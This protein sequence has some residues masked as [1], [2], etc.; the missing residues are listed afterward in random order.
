MTASY[1]KKIAA[2]ALAVCT[3]CGGVLAQSAPAGSPVAKHGQLKVTNGKIVDQNGESFPM[4]GMSFFWSTPS[5]EGAK[6]YNEGTVKWLA[7]DWKVDIVRVAMNPS[8]RGDWETVVSAAIKYGIYVIIDWH[9]HN[10]SGQQGDA[11]TFFSTVSSKYKGTPNVL[12]EVYNEPC[13]KGEQSG[14]CLGEDWSGIRSYA[15]AVV[16]TIRTNDKNNLIIIGSTDYSKRVDQAAEN[17]VSGDNLVYSV[18]YY[19]AEPG[20]YHQADL[21]AWCN[22]ALGKGLAL[23]VTEFGLSEADGGIKNNTKIDT[24]EANRWFSFLD[25]N[26]IGWM[27]WSICDKGEAASALKGGAGSTGNWSESNLTDGG[28]FIR[29]T[30]RRYT[31]TR[32]LNVTV[33]GAGGRVDISPAGG[34]NFPYGTPITLTA[35]TT[36][37]NWMFEGW[38]GGA[39]GSKSPLVLPP[40]YSDLNIT[41]TFSEGSMI[42]NGSF[43]NDYLNWSSAG[44]TLSHDAAGGFLKVSVATG[45]GAST[46]VQQTGLKIEAGKRY[47]LSFRAKT[48][49][50]TRN[51]TARITNSNRDRNYMDTAAVSLTTEW[52]TF[53]K[54]FSMCYKSS[55]G[56][57]VTDESAVLM[58]VCGGSPADA[59]EWHLDD[60]KLN[61][62]GTGSCS[63]TPVRFTALPTGKTMWSIS[64]VGGAVRLSGPVEAGAV[65]SLYDTRGKIVRSMAAK[66]GLTLNSAGI[67]TGNYLA[68]VKNGA[69]AEVYKTR[70]SLVR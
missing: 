37:G 13:P 12:Y 61:E 41:A 20:T 27:N 5:W 36:G 57:L 15:Q 22:T 18:H 46:R 11:Q 16:T 10:A 8:Q 32:K 31:E 67:P 2:A 66:D 63:G 33:N 47:T 62:T 19:T 51:L 38:S 59:W 53:E 4:R 70:F 65:L 26:G 39:S 42:K 40:L 9:S 3:L 44:V 64:Q 60:V 21:R 34:P 56:T 23:L 55:S 29:N 68:V 43:T 7:E 69:G 52:K 30:L 58:F 25:Q 6:Y 35:T 48:A 49:S 17:P 54:E 28:K 50:G 14:A 24:L 45:G 1:K